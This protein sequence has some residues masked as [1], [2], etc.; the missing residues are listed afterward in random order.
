MF[1]EHKTIEKKMKQLSN[2]EEE[3]MTILWEN[4]SMFVKDIQEMYDEPKPHI[5][6]LS[7]II[8]IL[9][10]KGMVG[11]ESLGKTY[12]YHAVVSK[13]NYSRKSVNTIVEKYFN[14]SH[15]EIVSS[16]IKKED[17]SIDELRQLIERVEKA[18]KK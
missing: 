7:T 1:A 2:R 6:T 4:G 9:E 18:H 11:H 12:K 16:F 8:R 15:L 10:D 3:I 5:N 13:E 17:I 14:N